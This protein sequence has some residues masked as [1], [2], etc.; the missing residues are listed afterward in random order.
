MERSRQAPQYWFLINKRRQLNC[1]AKLLTKMAW[2]NLLSC[3]THKCFSF[4]VWSFYKYHSFGLTIYCSLYSH[5]LF[6]LWSFS[7]YTLAFRVTVVFAFGAISL[8]KARNAV[9]WFQGI[10]M[11]HQILDTLIQAKERWIKTETFGILASI[12]IINESHYN[13]TLS[14]DP[15]MQ[16]GL[17]FR[18][19]TAAYLH[20]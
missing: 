2:H 3:H 13:V 5:S 9:F 7:R 20:K 18:F 4:L 15:K 8:F 6:P 10:P 17:I 11:H 19:Q 14:I 16:N 12:D 1:L